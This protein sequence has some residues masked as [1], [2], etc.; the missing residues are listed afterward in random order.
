M[1]LMHSMPPLVYGCLVVAPRS[2][3]LFVCVAVWLLLG[4]QT[5]HCRHE[6]GYLVRCGDVMACPRQIWRTIRCCH[7]SSSLDV[8]RIVFAATNCYGVGP[9][10][11]R[12]ETG[13]PPEVLFSE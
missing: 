12:E 5:C 3:W 2:R 10:C 1:V 8:D 4:V 6:C 13:S 9:P 7:R 11:A